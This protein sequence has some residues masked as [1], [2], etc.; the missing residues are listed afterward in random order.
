MPMGFYAL[1]MLLTF[2][3]CLCTS[4]YAYGFLC[5][6]MHAYVCYPFAYGS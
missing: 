5:L 2:A 6:F 3:A 1:L 4:I